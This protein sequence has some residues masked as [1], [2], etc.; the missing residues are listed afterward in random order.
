MDLPPVVRLLL[1]YC[2]GKVPRY[3]TVP[4]S[5]RSVHGC[6]AVVQWEQSSADA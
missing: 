6:G 1:R 5:P 4:G 2:T 3:Y